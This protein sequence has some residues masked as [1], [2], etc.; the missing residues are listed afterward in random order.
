MNLKK[1]KIISIFTTLIITTISHFMYDLFPNTL[2]SIFFPV[3]ESIWEHMKM[4]YTSFLI[5]GILEYFIIKK[6]NIKVNN[7]IFNSF[8]SSILS[9]IIYLIIYLPFYYTIGNNEIVI[10]TTLILD[11]IIVN[12]ISYF[13]LKN[14]ELNL[15]KISIILIIITYIIMIYL[16]Y[17]PPK[18][19][20][21]IDPV[22]NTY[23]IQK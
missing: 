1:I 9:I 21:F 11:I 2:F 15:K 10:F 5:N 8:I 18:F 12:I 20:L 14:K 13:I 17:K 16:T 3:N 23:G 4:L 7:L 6:T 19:S 22:T